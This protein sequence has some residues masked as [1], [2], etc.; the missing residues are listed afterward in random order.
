MIEVVICESQSAFTSREI[1]RIEP[2]RLSNTLHIPTLLLRYCRQLT[3]WLSCSSR[4]H[5]R[6]ESTM[7]IGPSSRLPRDSVEIVGQRYGSFPSPVSDCSLR[8]LL[9]SSNNAWIW[10]SSRSTVEPIRC[11]KTQMLPFGVSLK[12]QVDVPLPNKTDWMTDPDYT[13]LVFEN[14][15]TS[16]GKGGAPPFAELI[17]RAC[18]N[19]EDMQ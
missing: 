1:N 17:R 8:E 2:T 18:S 6:R 16:C 15:C 9:H 10:T 13:R 7:I 3:R 12:Q 5:A 4:G 11:T 14:D 19:C